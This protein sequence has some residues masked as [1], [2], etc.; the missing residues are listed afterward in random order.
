MMPGISVQSP[1]DNRG[2][3]V[4]Q[5]LVSGSTP[6]HLL[7]L[8]HASVDRL[9]D[10][11]LHMRGRNAHFAGAAAKSTWTGIGARCRR[12]D[13]RIFWAGAPKDGSGAERREESIH[14]VAAG[15]SEVRAARRDH[16]FLF[17]ANSD[18]PLLGRLA[19]WELR[20]T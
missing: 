17:S 11:E 10:G 12:K 13:P 8:A 1:I 15:N 20:H 3:H 19:T 6:A 2:F 16:V 5:V 18:L 7:L 9:I 14:G 4:K